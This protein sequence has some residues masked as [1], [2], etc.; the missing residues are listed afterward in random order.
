MKNER[1][2]QHK[3]LCGCG[4]HASK[5]IV[6]CCDC[7]QKEDDCGCKDS[8]P[9]CGEARKPR[10]PESPPAPGW[11]AGDAPGKNPLAGAKD[12]NDKKRLFDKAVIDI[13]RTGSGPKGPKF[14][15]R[16][17]EYLPY[18]VIRANAGDR[19]ARPLSGVFWESPDIFVAPNLTAETAPNSPTTSAG[20][21]QAGVPNTLWAH[22]WNLGQAPVYNARV[23]F[24]WFDPTLGFNEAAA[25]LIGVAYVDLGNRSSAK[26]HAYV[27]CPKS[28]VPQFL[29]GGHEC[30]MA[31]CFEPLTDPLGPNP[32][33][34]S[35][36]RH[37]G[38]R[39]IHVQNASSPATVQIALRLGCGVGPGTASLEIHAVE[40]IKFQWLSLLAGKKNQVLREAIKPVVVAGILPPALWSKNNIRPVFKN[41]TR[42]TAQGILRPR[43]EFERGCEELE[44]TVYI[45]VD[46]LEKGE[47]KVFRVEQRKDGK[48][49]GGYTVIARK[50]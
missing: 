50:A 28:W 34:A 42:E 13:L 11:N 49:V 44:A 24:Y 4:C 32:W 35:D 43:I 14:G 10:R 12:E 26:A 39:N 9:C 38:Q 6:I 20:L 1:Q 7:R 3:T 16:K 29:N 5:V 37:V 19:G 15:P 25:N 46:G 31:R 41:L 47:C 23:E 40:A 45:S 2:G 18:L 30:L 48:L 17:D 8:K 33:D 22:V 21:A 27:K 36:D